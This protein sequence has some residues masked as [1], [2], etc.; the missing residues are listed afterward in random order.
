MELKTLRPSWPGSYEAL[1]HATDRPAF[2]LHLRDPV[3]PEVRDE[4]MASRLQRAVGVIYRPETER[5][6]HYFEATLPSQFDSWIWFDQTR[7]VQPI[8]AGAR[9]VGSPFG[10]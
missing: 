8:E 9:S 1:C 2:L 6:S 3:R 7:A 10:A 5:L 4:L